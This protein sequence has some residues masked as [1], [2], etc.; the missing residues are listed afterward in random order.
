LKKHDAV[1]ETIKA[2]RSGKNITEYLRKLN[3]IEYNSPEIIEL[4]YDLQ[5]GSY[6]EYAR[7]NMQLVNLYTNEIAQII[8]T[9]LNHNDSIL[10]IGSGELTTIS[11]VINKLNKKPR[12]LYCID[13]SWSR[14]Y[15]GIS[16]AKEILNQESFSRISPIVA[17]ISKIPL[18][19]KS[20]N[21][22]TSS[23]ALEPNGENLRLIL[24]ELFR[25]TIDKIILFEPSYEMNSEIGRERMDKLGYIKN[26]K[27]TVES[28]GGT[29]IEFKSI[30]NI[31]N[32]LNPTYCYIIVPPAQVGKDV[33]RNLQIPP[34]FTFPGSDSELIEFDEFLI[35]R[36]TGI[37]F[38]KL[39]RIPILKSTSSILATALLD[40]IEL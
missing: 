10:D 33:V 17:E 22:T 19:S 31:S 26:I 30:T 6:I 1:I 21:V 29:I 34:D 32:P 13:I 27:G 36:F 15:K 7:K 39:K 11:N 18:H 12:I 2:F 14:L 24:E 16:Y 5:A 25:V 4:A 37:L 3:N 23:H 28:L 38:P 40:L 20:I 8:D 35:S 9:N